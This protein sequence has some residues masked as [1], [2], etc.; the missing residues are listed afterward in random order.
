[1]SRTP[2]IWNT[3]GLMR[4]IVNNT[5]LPHSRIEEYRNRT[6][7]TMVTH[8]ML[9]VPFYRNL[10]TQLNINP[11]SFRGVEDLVMLPTVSKAQLC[12]LPSSELIDESQDIDRLQSIST[13][14]STGRPFRIY[15]T[16]LEIRRLH[17]YRLR[18]HRQF[19]RRIGDRI[20]E[21]DQPIKPHRNDKKYI[22][23]FLR[24]IGV[25]RRLQLSLYEDTDFLL[26]HLEAYRPHMVT[27]YPNVLQRL[28]KELAKDPRN[29]IKPRFLLTNSEVLTL[30]L[31]TELRENWGG[32]DVFQFYDCH[33]CNLIA[34]DCP[35]GHGLHCAD[36]L[37]IVEVLRNGRPVGYGERGEVTIT[38]L[39]SYAMPFI[40]F[41]LG[42]V[43][44][45]GPTPCPCGQPFSTL[46]NVEGR[47]VDFFPL[48]G[49]RWLHPYRIIENL[50]ND[51]GD[52]V[53]QYRL[54]Q[55]RE[56][57]IV[58]QAVPTSKATPERLEQFRRYAKEA[59]GPGVEVI[60]QFVD[61]L[62]IGSGGKFRPARSLI[63]TDY[64]DVNWDKVDL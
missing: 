16:W 4:D 56:D 8:A 40:R 2:S 59:V 49:G 55:E 19:G 7:K 25:E 54:L 10:Y 35:E 41:Q 30:G 57:R 43:A 36:D 63:H 21:I 61:K 27:A 15:N 13:T 31:R 9:Q 22:G 64:G 44:T 58:F 45:L 42:D 60:A 39:H 51:G 38:S 11:S 26:D 1:M 28:G 24:G 3:L 6:L 20:V 53:L 48:P 34:W 29:A 18:A 33:E 32:T 62:E 14:G 12:D 47:L 46:L 5:K 37:V 17:L 50:D 23:N 52:W